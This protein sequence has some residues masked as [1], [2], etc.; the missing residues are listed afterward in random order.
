MSYAII[1][2]YYGHFYCI[3]ENTFY[4]SSCVTQDNSSKLDVVDTRVPASH[5][6]Y[7]Y[8][9]NR[10]GQYTIE[11]YDEHLQLLG[12]AGG[13]L[14]VV[15]RRNSNVICRTADPF[16]SSIGDIDKYKDKFVVSG[17]N[18]YVFV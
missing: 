5:A 16:V 17:L 13:Q 2:K 7:N 11:E 3:E 10:F 8:I 9:A 14:E 18:E 12:F 4:A 15:D 6:T 1:D